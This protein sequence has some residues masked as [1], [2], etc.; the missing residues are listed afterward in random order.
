MS[1]LPPPPPQ[2]PEVGLT[3]ALTELVER[4]HHILAKP[5]VP[6]GL[7]RMW[8]GQMQVQIRKAYGSNSHAEHWWPLPPEMVPPNEA[9]E[10]LTSRLRKAQALLTLINEAPAKSLAGVQGHRVFI[11]HGRSPLWREFKDFLQERLRLPWDEFN[12]EPVA[13]IATTERLQQL[14]ESSSFAFL[15]MTGE[16]EHADQTLHARMNVVHEVGLFQGKLGNRRA[17]VLL[18]D[19]CQSFS[20]IHGLTCI[21][22]PRGRISA[23]FEEVRRVLERE[24]ITEA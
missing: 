9:K 21:P 1:S 16:D 24:G 12:R 15:I 22:F 11:G 8:L 2:K 20:N 23:A 3:Q 10:L 18:E 14:L 7:L 17:I 5:Q 19:G 13:G 4:G 6:P